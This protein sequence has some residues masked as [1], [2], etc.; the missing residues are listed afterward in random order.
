V[1]VTIGLDVF[2]A[3]TLPLVVTE[4]IR[5]VQHPAG[6]EAQGRFRIGGR[7]LAADGAAVAGAVVSLVEAGLSTT[8]GADGRYTIGPAAPGTHTL[9]AQSGALAGTVTVAI[10]RPAGSPP[11]DVELGTPS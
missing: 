3:E 4:E 10:P 6:G 1:T 7:V 8:T 2:A 11:Y 9:R 5:I